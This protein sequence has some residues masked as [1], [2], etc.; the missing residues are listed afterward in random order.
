MAMVAQAPTVNKPAAAG[1]RKFLL[2]REK[3]FALLIDFGYNGFSRR[4]P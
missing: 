2:T 4:R 3:A 1:E